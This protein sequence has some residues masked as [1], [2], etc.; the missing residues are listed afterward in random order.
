MRLIRDHLSTAIGQEIHGELIAMPAATLPAP[1]RPTLQFST[2][3]SYETTTSLA[4]IFAPE[5]S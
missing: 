2:A 1:I 3:T 5:S 4:F